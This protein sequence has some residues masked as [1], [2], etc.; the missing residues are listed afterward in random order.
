MVRV[1]TELGATAVEYSLIAAL[2]AAVIV[3][4]VVSLGTE[5]LALFMTIDGKF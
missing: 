5:V 2:I 4:A 1:R 3:V